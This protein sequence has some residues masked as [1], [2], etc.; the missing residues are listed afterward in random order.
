MSCTMV[1]ILIVIYKAIIGDHGVG[2]MAGPN[3]QSCPT[4]VKIT[5][6]DKILSYLLTPRA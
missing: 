1:L 2:W 3:P 4:P 6:F 5:I